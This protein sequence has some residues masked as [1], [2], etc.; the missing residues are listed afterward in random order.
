MYIVQNIIFID[1]IQ[2]YTYTSTCQY[3]VSGMLSIRSK[4]RLLNLKTAYIM[5]SANMTN[6][7]DYTA[8][9]ASFKYCTV[10]LYT[11]YSYAQYSNVQQRLP[12]VALKQ[13]SALWPKIFGS[14]MKILNTAN[15][16]PH[17]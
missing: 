17:V 6:H 8:V 1:F 14:A 9:D 11:V 15:L 5:L 13:T 2:S 16:P 7:T 3:C 12:T 10:V 4:I